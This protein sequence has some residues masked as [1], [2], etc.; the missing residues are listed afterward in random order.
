MTITNNALD[1]ATV[2][3]ASGNTQ[4]ISHVAIGSGTNIPS[5]T[6]NTLGSEFSRKTTTN[7][8]IGSPNAGTTFSAVWNSVDA[9]GAGDITELGLFSA[10]TVATGSMWNRTKFDAISLNDGSNWKFQIVVK[11]V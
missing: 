2:L 1:M 5:I 8:N 11:E 10:A 7:A 3:V 4:F 6:E 9:S